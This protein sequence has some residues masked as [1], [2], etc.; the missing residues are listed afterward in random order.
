MGHPF[1][2]ISFQLFRLGTV[3][4][5]RQRV[6]GNTAVPWEP[7]DWAN[8]HGGLGKGFF[9]LLFKCHRALASHPRHSQDLL[10]CCPPAFSVLQSFT[11]LHHT[12]LSQ[13][14][15]G[16]FIVLSCQPSQES[17]LEQVF[18]QHLLPLFLPSLTLPSLPPSSDASLSL[19]SELYGQNILLVFS[20]PSVSGIQ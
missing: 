7:S 20:R 2:Q 19:L 13:I 12:S 3:A 8:L 5:A 16:F 6:L 10:Q 4:P 1:T 9:L 18:L 14:P 15:P 17:L 11:V